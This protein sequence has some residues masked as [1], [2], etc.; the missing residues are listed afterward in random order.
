MRRERQSLAE[1][2]RE[3]IQD[4][5]ETLPTIFRGSGVA[6]PVLFRFMRGERDLTLRTVDKLCRYLGLHLTKNA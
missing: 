6:T 1:V 5:G 2:L 3:T 4:S